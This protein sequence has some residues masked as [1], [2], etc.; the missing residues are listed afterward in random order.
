MSWKNV[1]DNDVGSRDSTS[2]TI[3]DIRKLFYTSLNDILDYDLEQLVKSNFDPFTSILIKK[4]NPL[5]NSSKG[6]IID[7][8]V[9]NRVNL[10]GN[11][12]VAYMKDFKTVTVENDLQISG[13]IHIKSTEDPNA[14]ITILSSNIIEVVGARMRGYYL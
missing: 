4:T 14:V 12:I 8:F 2:R 11:A 10:Y 7:A 9:V 5:Y 1:I 6:P 13:A 3:A